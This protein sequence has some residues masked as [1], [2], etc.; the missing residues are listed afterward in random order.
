MT[1]TANIGEIRVPLMVMLGTKELP[2][3]EVAAIG[4]G[5]II[6]L[7]AIAG[8]PVTLLAS[9]EAVAKGEVVVIDENFGIRVTELIAEPPRE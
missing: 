2:V 9:G 6:A 3:S 5:T 8:E 1:K 4:P 7:D